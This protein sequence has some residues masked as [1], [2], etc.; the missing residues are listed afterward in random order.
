M[1]RNELARRVLL[2]WYRAVAVWRHTLR[3]AAD[4]LIP[5]TEIS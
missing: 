2:K 3:F 1:A 5:F 4:Q